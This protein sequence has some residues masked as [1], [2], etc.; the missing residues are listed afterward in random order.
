MGSTEIAVL[1]VGVITAI[2]MGL[3]LTIDASPAPGEEDEHRLEFSE[4]YE[5]YEKWNDTF[6]CGS[7]GHRFIPVTVNT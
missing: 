1:I 3:S 6:S 7:C 5:A 4:E 2:G